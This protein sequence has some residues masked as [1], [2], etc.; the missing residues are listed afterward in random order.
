[1]W[2][3][4]TTVPMLAVFPQDDE[5]LGQTEERKMKDSLASCGARI[6]T[7]PGGHLECLG[8]SLRPLRGEMDFM[9]RAA[10]LDGMSAK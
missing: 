9:R 3:D 6:I 5:L 4:A 8:A 10:S 1:M 7:V 2:D